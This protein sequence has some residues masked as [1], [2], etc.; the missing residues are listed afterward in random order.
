V[1][2]KCEDCAAPVDAPGDRWCLAC[3]DKGFSFVSPQ[4]YDECHH[5][6]VCVDGEL[7]CAHCGAEG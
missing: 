4:A 7:V 2:E 5:S 6:P 1:S 3:L